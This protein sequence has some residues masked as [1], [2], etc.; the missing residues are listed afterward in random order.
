MIIKNND[1]TKSDLTL[2]NIY[3][4]I[5]NIFIAQRAEK[6]VYFNRVLIYNIERVIF[7]HILHLKEC[8]LAIKEVKHFSFD[9][10][11]YYGLPHLFDNIN[12]NVE[13][14]KFTTDI[15]FDVDEFRFTLCKRVSQ[16]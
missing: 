14:H 11:E 2:F 15:I 4:Y 3:I 6:Y 13:E 16:K 8:F 9:V 5:F 12:N 1:V 10:A 7:G